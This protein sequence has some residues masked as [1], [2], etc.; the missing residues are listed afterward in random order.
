[1]AQ[2]RSNFLCLLVLLAAVVGLGATHRAQACSQGMSGS[3]HRSCCDGM[4]SA[5][6]PAP[7]VQHA[8]HDGATA[9]GRFRGCAGTGHCNCGQPVHV[10]ATAREV[11]P[12]ILTPSLLPVWP[13]PRIAVGRIPPSQGP[14]DSGFADLPARHTYLATL[15]LR[16]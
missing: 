6:M 12:V 3:E 14:P 9:F 10:Q 16:I 2:S 5:A 7:N 1:M 4:D 15:R 8:L 13:G 11:R